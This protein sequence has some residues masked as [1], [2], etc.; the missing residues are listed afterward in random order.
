MWTQQS[1]LLLR[2]WGQLGNATWLSLAKSDML[3]A[4]AWAVLTPLILRLATVFPLQRDKIVGRVAAYVALGAAATIVH[5]ALWHVLTQSTIFA[6]AYEMTF[7]VG[8]LIFCAIVGVGHRQR[9]IDWIR[10]REAAAA[11]L[12]RRL[13]DA[14]LRAGKLQL[15]PPVLLRALDGIA[16]TARRD[17]E[18]TERQL[19]VLADYLRIA[20]ECTD[21]R[22]VTPDR[23]RSL[24]LAVAA[25]RRTGAYSHD[26]TLSA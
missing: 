25:L 21:A 3:S 19:T 15:I 1:F 6:A 5:A 12:R 16:E 9:L 2:M 17:P 13:D 7:I 11:D 18:L 23:E 4:V 20:L 24:E 8:F 10:S 14:Q 22:G 26:L